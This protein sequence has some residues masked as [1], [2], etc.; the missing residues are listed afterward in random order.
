MEVPCASWTDLR[1]QWW[2]EIYAW[3]L[4]K[5]PDPVLSGHL[6]T[7]C[8]HISN[9]FPRPESFIFPPRTQLVC[10]TRFPPF[11]KSFP[12]WNITSPFDSAL[13]CRSLSLKSC[14]DP[15]QHQGGP[16]QTP[17]WHCPDSPLL[18]LE[19]KGRSSR[20][21]S[22]FMT[23]NFPSSF[24]VDPAWCFSN[25]CWPNGLPWKKPPVLSWDPLGPGCRDD[26]EIFR[27]FVNCW[28]HWYMLIGHTRG[29]YTTET[30]P[31]YESG[32]PTAQSQFTSTNGSTSEPVWFW[33]AH[34]TPE[35]LWPSGAP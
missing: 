13:L 22:V 7:L 19:F 29:M 10:P 14:H 20:A 25:A 17:L 28:S 3:R 27:K 33:E 18:S 34:R 23:S 32:Q 35:S 5:W 24:T 21:E 8:W 16:A 1:A 12:V 9:E 26:W 2:H 30:G 31:H 15:E 4:C 6:L 11:P